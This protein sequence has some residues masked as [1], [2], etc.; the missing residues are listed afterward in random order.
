MRQLSSPYL[1]EQNG[2]AKRRN[3][4]VVEVA[5]AMLFENDVPKPFWREA[6]NKTIY[7]LNRVQLRK[8]M[9]KASYEL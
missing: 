4:L 8:C 6:F 5:R 3:R 1:P 9:D 7:T 2:I